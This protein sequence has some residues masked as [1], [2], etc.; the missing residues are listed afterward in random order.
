MVPPCKTDEVDYCEY[1]TLVDSRDGQVYKT[2]KIGDQWWMAENLKYEVCGQ[3][4]YLHALYS[5]KTAQKAC[6]PGWHLPSKQ[7]VEVLFASVGGVSVAGRKLSARDTSHGGMFSGT[8]EYGFS[9]FNVKT[10]FEDEPYEKKIFGRLR[11]I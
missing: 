3:A 9:A 4:S 2:V 1:G 11:H 6:P 5:W 7:E 10:Y 8:D